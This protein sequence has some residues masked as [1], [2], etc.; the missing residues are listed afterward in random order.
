MG[1]EPKA[2]RTGVEPSAGK[3]EPTGEK[4]AAGRP[5]LDRLAALLLAIPSIA[6]LVVA[7]LLEPDPS[8]IGTHQ[9]LG[10]GTCTMLAITGWPCPMCGM[11]TCFSLAV[12]GRLFS[13]FMTQPFG[14][15]LF[16]VTAVVA[17]TSLL[18]LIRPG[19]RWLRF[20]DWLGPREGWVAGALMAG[21]VVGWLHNLV[22]AAL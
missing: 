17:L 8:G 19:G 3:N 15:L 13:A 14:L 9:Q 16:L 21:L 10:L 1:T 12:R 18:E 6:V 20:W 5:A 11:T 2:G 22:K 4:K 7:A